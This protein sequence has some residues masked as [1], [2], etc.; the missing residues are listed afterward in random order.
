MPEESNEHLIKEC[1]RIEED[2]L[3]TAEAHYMLASEAKRTS[4]WVKFLPA[5]VAAV[6]GIL[7]LRGYPD[8]LAWLA[9][10]S[11]AAFGLQA[12]LDPDRK[13]NDYSI[14][15]KEYTALKHEARALYQTFSHE[16]DHNAFALAVRI[17][18]E[19][20]NALVRHTPQT[21]IKAFEEGRKRIKAGRHTP[22]FEEKELAHE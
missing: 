3:Y 12:V 10:I 4:F 1:M 11:G 2:S 8:W 22:D 15:G 18:R 21:T 17:L 9:I 20:Y 7:V 19:K 5:V 14:A 6:S 16:M 13:A